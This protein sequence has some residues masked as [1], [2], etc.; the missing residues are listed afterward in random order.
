[1]LISE[2]AMCKAYEVLIAAKITNFT[3]I[4]SRVLLI[5][6]FVLFTVHEEQNIH[7]HLQTLSLHHEQEVMLMPCIH[8]CL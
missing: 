5:Y 6:L 3:Y 7:G 8:L 4:P 1:M 2:T